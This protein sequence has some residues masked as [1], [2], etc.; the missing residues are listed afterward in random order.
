MSHRMSLEAIFSN[1]RNK[2]LLD[3]TFSWV[4]Q[5]YRWHKNFEAALS[6]ERF[7]SDFFRFYTELEIENEEEGSLNNRDTSMKLGIRYLL[8]Y[9][10]ELDMSLDHRAR[11][12]IELDYEILLTP[13]LE[14][15]TDWSLKADAGFSTKTKNWKKEWSV[16]GEYILSKNIS[17]KASYSNHF[18]WG[19]GLNIKY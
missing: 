13:R 16:G 5:K 8:P 14:V 10:I 3:T 11:W 4:D 2:I 15:F 6:Y 1:T 19:A 7:T 17:L 12:E 18:G 9:L